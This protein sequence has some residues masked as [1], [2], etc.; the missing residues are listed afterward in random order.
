MTYI[1]DFGLRILELTRI[2]SSFRNPKSRIMNND[3]FSLWA[4]QRQAPTAGKILV[5]I[6][7]PRAG[8]PPA[9]SSFLSHI[10]Y[11]ISR[12]PHLASRI[13][14]LPQL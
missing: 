7:H 9:A 10:P 4:W 2:Q 3:C 13:S 1:L 14:Y 8:L 5:Y 11:P 6:P 12:I